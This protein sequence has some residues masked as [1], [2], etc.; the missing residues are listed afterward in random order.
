MPAW[1]PGGTGSRRRPR[2]PPG[3]RPA[4]GG[5]G[6]E[7]D[8]GADEGGQLVVEVDRVEPG[9]ALQRARDREPG[10][11]E[12]GHQHV[13]DHH[14]RLHRTGLGR[15]A[16]RHPER[17][18]DEA[19]QPD[20]RDQARPLPGVQPHALGHAERED[21]QDR[22]QRGHRAGADLGHRVGPPGQRGQPQL[23]HPAALALQRD[24]LR[25]AGEHRADRA[26]G[27]HRDHEVRLGAH[28]ARHAVAV[29]ADEEEVH[30]RGVEDGEEQV[31]PV[32][33]GAQDL[34]LDQGGHRARSVSARL[35]LCESWSSCSPV[36]VR[37]ACSRPRLVTSRPRG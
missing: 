24:P 14:D 4:R 10:P 35:A 9:D 13:D 11:A 37:K 33:Q 26:E 16:E 30:Q 23:A 25:A 20:H 8:A 18:E 1:C 7:G 3:T 28:P 34:Q 22:R 31:P 36:M 27:G 17:R 12:G 6:V 19:A 32:A 15:V 5:R 21:H 29:R 2:R